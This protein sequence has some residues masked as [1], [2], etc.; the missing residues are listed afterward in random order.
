[1]TSTS[2]GHVITGA[3]IWLEGA[4]FSLKHPKLW[5]YFAFPLLLN[6]FLITMLFY[7]GWDSLFSYLPDVTFHNSATSWKTWAYW[8]LGFKACFT[9]LWSLMLWILALLL[10]LLFYVL[11]FVYLASVIGAPFY[12]RLSLYVEKENGVQHLDRPFTFKKDLWMP[13][14]FMLKMSSFQILFALFCFPISFF[15]LIGTLLYVVLMAIPVTLNLIAYCM[16]RRFIRFREQVAFAW[17]WRYDYLGFGMVAFL[18]IAP[19]GLGIVTLP[20]S[21]VGA[22]L[23]FLKNHS[24][25]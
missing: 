20:L 25:Q 14:T 8:G 11:C 4:T 12:E 7:W 6:F 17:Q 21:V 16:E 9:F 5:I 2:H 22:T 15:P 10:M 19:F 1:M 13:M 23:L 18:T 3:K 24:S